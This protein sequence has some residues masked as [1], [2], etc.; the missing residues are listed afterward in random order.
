MADTYAS[1]GVRGIGPMGKAMSIAGMVVGGILTLMFALDLVLGIPFGG[2]QR[3]M[4]LGFVMSS[5]IL[6][7]LS[8]NAFRDAS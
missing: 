2:L 7:Y 6:T 4:D 1:A 5:L 3:M 8:W